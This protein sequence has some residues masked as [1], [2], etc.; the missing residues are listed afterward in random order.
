VSLGLAPAA[1]PALRDVDDA[2]DAQA[3]AARAPGTRFAA[4]LDAMRA[5]VAA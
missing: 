4:T 3:V 2:A 1:L 5:A